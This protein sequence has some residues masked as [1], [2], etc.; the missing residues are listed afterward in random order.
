MPGPNLIQSVGG[1]GQKAT[2]WVSLFTSRFFNGLVTNRSLLRGPLGSIY[3]D[4]YHLGTTDV[5]CDG[6]NTELS[7]RLTM[8]RRPGN[9]K[10][11]SA[12]SGFAFDT[13]YSFHES[14]G[15]ILTIGDGAEYVNLLTTSSITPIFAKDSTSGQ[16]YF[17]GV[18]TSLYIGDGV[19]LV[20]YIPGVTNSQTGKNI[21]NFG[22]AAPM[23]A[24]TL[25]VVETGSAGVAWQVNTMFTTMGLITDGTNVYQLISTMQNGNTTQFGTTGSG[26][27]AFSNTVGGV[28]TDGTCHWNCKGALGLWVAGTTYSAAQPIYDPASNGVYVASG[29][30][31]GTVR[32][33]FN[34]TFNTHTTSKAGIIWQYIGPPAL[35]QPSTTYNA[36]W[37]FP[38]QMIIEP[39]IGTSPANMTAIINAGTQTMFVQT[40]NDATTGSTN[41]PGTS[42]SGYTPWPATFVAQNTVTDGNNLWV[43]LNP[44]S[45]AAS[46]GY[47]G[48]Q[49]GSTNFNAIIDGNG[50]FQVALTTGVS[51][52][53]TPYN[54]W[55]ASHSFVGGSIIAVQ[56]LASPTGFTAFK[57]NGATGTSGATQPATWNFTLAAT[58]TDGGVTWTSQGPTT[59]GVAVWGQ[60]YG[61]QTADNTITWSC[62]GTAA[63]STWA[64]NTI[65]YLPA[66]GFAPPSQSQ[67]YGGASVIG[68]AF[69]QFVT[70]SGKSGSGSAPSWITNPSAIPNTVVDNTVTWT[71][72]SPFSALGFTWT[73]GY[74]YVFAFKARGVN[75]AY[76]TTAPPLQQAGMGSP[77]IIGPLGPPMGCQDGSVST[78]SPVGMIIGAQTVGAQIII[79]G[80]GSI[81]PQYDT[82]EVYRSTDGFYLGGPF[83]FLTDIA[84]PPLNA[85]GQP[86]TWSVIDFMTDVPEVINGV[87]LP[88]LN[89][90]IEAPVDDQNDPP[91]GQYGSL[92]F[93]QSN[94]NTPTRP[95][96]GTGLIGLTYH[97]GRLFG[98]IGNN[99]Y[100][101]GGPDTVVGNGFTAWPPT[102]VFPFNSNVVRLLSTTSG[103]LVFTTSG[104][105]LI[106]GGPAITTYY[107]QLLVDGLGLVSWNALTLMLGVPHIFSS[108]H[109]LLGIEP[110]QGVTRVGHPI[111]DLLT[112]FNPA[113]VYL[114]YHSY[115]DL[116]HALY[117]A[118]GSSQWYRCDTNLAPDSQTV[119]PVWSP[120]ATIAG[121]IGAIASV[122]TSPGLRQL[123]ISPV[124]SGFIL[125]RDSTYTI[126]SDRGT[127]GTGASGTAYSAFFTIG[128]IVFATAGQMAEMGFICGDYIKTGSQPTVSVLFDELSATNGATF[129]SIS[130]FMVSDPPRLYGPT[131]TPATMWSNRYYFSQTTSANSG[132]APLPAW[133]KHMQIKV[134][135]QTD[136]VQNEM[137][138]FTVWGS[139]WTE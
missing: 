7:T 92:F 84:M 110:G 46:T 138:A 69:N 139:L 130:A 97:Q 137:L 131:A 65:W 8:I 68:S 79:S 52:A 108:D 11:S 39:I 6:L 33:K 74:G 112:Q 28:I 93:S 27:P 73:K 22:G 15:T 55:L 29:G 80:P 34:P 20:K 36:Y 61:A 89:E 25:T 101:S 43:A 14:T 82:I 81:D 118:D 38:K 5:L 85:N 58:T 87:T 115:G 72:V 129:E 107:S 119:G 41:N 45:W 67:P 132:G 10:W 13:F 103:L 75:D 90:L 126:F 109:Q 94:I 86:G 48:W 104:L 53:V 37:E 98:F 17:Q 76:V 105:Y 16:S 32:P 123:L 64:T 26:A 9:P 19:D 120:K 117:I 47:N 54:G 116:D 136:V 24:P 88:G 100:A 21:F 106:G 18:D 40:N 134:D 56:N 30:T 12:T 70:Q 35:W 111:G 99:V 4:F 127:V 77:N 78:A 62:V 113:N 59:A 121:G 63:H 51:G 1:Q 23:V 114:V 2:H 66:A 128:S 31:E 91:P 3:T 50:N 133:C 96:P 95:A 83:L 44:N 57:N 71:C 124:S 102:N 42:G 135:F 125:T 122:E 60:Q 49:Q